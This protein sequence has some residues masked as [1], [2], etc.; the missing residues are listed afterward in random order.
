MIYNFQGNIR[1][2][3][4]L[5]EH[6]FVLCRGSMIMPEHLPKEFRETVAAT[7]DHHDAV[8]LRGRFEESEV[9]LIKGALIRNRSHRG[10]TARELGIN[11]ST[12][13]RKMK[14]LDITDS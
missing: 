7:N 13:W 4:N 6:A 8:S 1:E 5:L 3:E 10:K 11:S 12:L 2:L 14:R 9:Q